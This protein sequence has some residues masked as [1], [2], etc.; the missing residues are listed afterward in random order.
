VT[1]IATTPN[2]S[3]GRLNASPSNIRI[4]PSRQSGHVSSLG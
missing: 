1:A 4:R 2:T 3:V